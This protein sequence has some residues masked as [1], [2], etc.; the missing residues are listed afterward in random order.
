MHST[1]WTLQLLFGLLFLLHGILAIRKPASMRTRLEKLPYSSAFLSFIGL[2]EI[3]G[4]LGLVLPLWTGIAAGLTP[5][6][7][8]GLA[9]IMA[10][11]VWTHLA[12]QEG[13]QAA[14]TTVI[15]LLLALIAY[16]RWSLL[17]GL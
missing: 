14:V 8:I 7:A 10:G 16:G 11:A 17:A 15:T 6:A 9:I 4:S 12:A 5:L 3:L 1:L 2:C 13:A